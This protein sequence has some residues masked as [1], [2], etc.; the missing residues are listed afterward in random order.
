MTI[1]P[2]EPHTAPHQDILPWHEIQ[3]PVVGQAQGQFLPEAFYLDLVAD[4]PN[5]DVQA[6]LNNARAYMERKFDQTP[7]WP[8][9]FNFLLNWMQRNQKRN[10]RMERWLG[11]AR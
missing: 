4:C 9:L 7:S 10:V 5:V 6:E 1:T 11:G 8:Q 2:D 3:W